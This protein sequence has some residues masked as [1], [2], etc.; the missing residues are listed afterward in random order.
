MC[1]EEKRGRKKK[2]SYLREKEMKANKIQ[3]K[4]KEIT[5]KMEKV[6]IKGRGRYTTPVPPNIIKQRHKSMKI[7]LEQQKPNE[8][9]G[10]NY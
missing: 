5:M 7:K 3:N 6:I 4:V 8:Y 10:L 1:V 2:L 9:E